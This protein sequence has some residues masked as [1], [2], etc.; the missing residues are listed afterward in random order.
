[1]AGLIAF[2]QRRPRRAA[3]RPTLVWAGYAAAAWAVLGLPMHV[4]R[5]L[6]GG[7]AVPLSTAELL[8]RAGHWAAALA[9]GRWPCWRWRSSSRGGGGPR[10]GC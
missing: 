10:P 7:A 4:Y 5:G 6:G 3:P 8:W 9:L 1:M 2:R